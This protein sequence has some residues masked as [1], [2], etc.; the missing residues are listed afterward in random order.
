MHKTYAATFLYNKYGE[1]EKEIFSFIM[2]GIELDKDTE[3]FDDIKY[4]VKK[5]QVSNALV[6]VLESKNVILISAAKPLPKAFKVFCAKDIK[7]SKNPEKM[8]VF[9]DVSNIIKKN[10]KTGR[11]ECNR[12]N[13]D[14]FISYLVSAM[15]TY[16]YY[17]DQ[18]RIANNSQLTLLG[19][20]AF[21]SLITYCIDY[22]CKISAMP[23]IKSKCIYLASLYYLSNILEK[24]YNNAGN[25]DLAKKIS[26]LSD[27]EADI[28]DM[29]ID[30]D[31]MQNIKYFVEG[32]ADILHLNKLTLDI[33]V[34][35]WMTV[36]GTGTVFG[37]EMFGSF[38]S[39]I[40]D[41]YVGAY[42]NNQKTIEKVLG[43][44]MVE[45]TKTILMI[46]AESV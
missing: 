39:I 14:I 25:R 1:Y 6:N 35:T 41:A 31:M 12:N 4:E 16:I 27:R 32:V 8:K 11:Y 40:T 7:N 24:D 26:N 46:G 18:K 2:N 10:E 21:S 30:K 23:S 15:H 19:A 3:D 36:F 13:I 45:F 42:V 22:K 5:R 37:L 34:E 28:I 17:A 38:A 29:N 44:T 33:L 20:K 43:S 9:I